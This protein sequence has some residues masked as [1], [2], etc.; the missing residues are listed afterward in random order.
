MHETGRACTDLIR[1]LDSRVLA[2]VSDRMFD[3][4]G[5]RREDIRRRW[6]HRCPN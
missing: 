4:R 3:S 1:L 6:G 2:L 5:F